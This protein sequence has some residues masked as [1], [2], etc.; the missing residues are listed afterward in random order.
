MEELIPIEIAR[1]DVERWLDAKRISERKRNSYSDHIDNMIDGVMTGNLIVSDDCII[2]Q[3]LNFPVDGVSELVYKLRLEV[4]DARKRLEAVSSGD[5]DGRI[6]AYISALTGKSMGQ[7][8]LLDT[9]DYSMAQNMAV[10]FL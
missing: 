4:R 6:T 1:K 9:V 8:G 7:I 2:T 3:K 5:A 10:F